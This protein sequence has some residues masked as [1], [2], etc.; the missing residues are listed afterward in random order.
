MSLMGIR[1]QT[2]LGLAALSFA[3]AVTGAAPVAW[4]ARAIGFAGRHW[5]EHAM[6]EL[7]SSSNR[8]ERN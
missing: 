8:C 3:V 6:T 4:A 5:A 2:L 7:Q 1:R